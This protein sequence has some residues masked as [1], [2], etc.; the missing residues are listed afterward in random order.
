MYKI[1]FTTALVIFLSWPTIALSRELPSSFDG[2]EALYQCRQAV[3]HYEGEIIEDLQPALVCMSVLAGITAYNDILTQ[4]NAE[5][6][7]CPS[8]DISSISEYAR[9]VVKY[10]EENAEIREQRG[11][12]WMIVALSTAYPC[13]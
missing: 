12:T 5:R 6:F 13:V 3:R 1:A 4:Q 11:P 2:N 7:I 9:V 8:N 10:L